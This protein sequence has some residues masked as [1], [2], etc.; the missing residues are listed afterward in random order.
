MFE[1]CENT[2]TQAV[3]RL[4]R[5]SFFRDSQPQIQMRMIQAFK[6]RQAV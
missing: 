4:L 3:N 2:Q 6:A 1:V 5:L